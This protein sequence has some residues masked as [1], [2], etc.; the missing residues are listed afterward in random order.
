M[1]SNADADTVVM[2]AVS[3]NHDMEYNLK[4]YDTEIG[5]DGSGFYLG[6]QRQR[7]GLARAFYG[8]PKLLVLDEPNSSLDAM[9]EQ[10]LKLLLNLQ[11]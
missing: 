1:D 4:A 6:G 10:A 2:A 5:P 8:T 7:V 9:G 11:R 3:R